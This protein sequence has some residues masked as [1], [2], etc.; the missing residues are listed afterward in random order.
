MDYGL[1]RTKTGQKLHIASTRSSRTICGARVA[2][3][4]KHLTH[5]VNGC[6]ACGIAPGT[7]A[8]EL[9]QFYGLVVR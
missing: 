1:V 3:R 2:M 8:A 5:H 4:V 6:E 7:T 9:G